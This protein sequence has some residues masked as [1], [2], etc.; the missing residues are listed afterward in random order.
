MFVKP[1]SASWR[2]RDGRTD[3]SPFGFITISVRCVQHGAAAACSRRGRDRRRWTSIRIFCPKRGRISP[4]ASA[5]INGRRCATP[6]I[7]PAAH[8]ATA[9]RATRCSCRATRTFAPSRV[10]A[11]TLPRASRTW[12]APTSICRSSRRRQSSSSG[13]GRRK[14]PRTCRRASTTRRSRCATRA[15][16]GFT[17]SARSHSRT[18]TSHAA[19]SSGQWP[20]DM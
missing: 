9:E 11:G 7:C 10:R 8:T 18:S 12:T 3:S 19:S 1:R 15:A 16:A 6:A 20:P 2:Q 17:P 13:T 5:E 14:W 4:R